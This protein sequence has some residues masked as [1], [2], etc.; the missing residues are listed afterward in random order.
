MLHFNGYESFIH[1]QEKFCFMIVF[2]FLWNFLFF[3]ELTLASILFAS[4]FKVPIT[5]SSQTLHKSCNTYDTTLNT[6]PH[7]ETTGNL[8]IPACFPLETYFLTLSIFFP[9][10]LSDVIWLFAES[11]LGFPLFG[12]PVSN[13]CSSDLFSLFFLLI[14]LFC[15]IKPSSSFLRKCVGIGK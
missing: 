2:S 1:C 6:F 4:F 13:P 12:T 9:L 8:S 15:C 5:N 7:I 14:I 3:L 10:C 11:T